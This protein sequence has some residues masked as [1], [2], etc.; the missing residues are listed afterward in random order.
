M[1][2]SPPHII[3]TGNLS[4]KIYA[5][6]WKSQLTMNCVKLDVINVLLGEDG[7][8]GGGRPQIQSQ[9]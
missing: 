8:G 2:I 6:Y 9:K 7:W 1:P 3:P 5:C 4:D